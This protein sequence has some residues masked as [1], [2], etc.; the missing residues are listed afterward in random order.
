MLSKAAS[1]LLLLIHEMQRPGVEPPPGQTLRER[2]KA[3]LSQLETEAERNGVA[4]G[5]IDDAKYALVATIDETLAFSGWASKLGFDIHPLQ[6]E[7]FGDRNAGLRFYEKLAAVRQRSPEVLEV[8]HLCLALGFKG[9]YRVGGSEE[10]DHLMAEI[11]S[12]LG[13]DEEAQFA[14]ALSDKP[15]EPPPRSVPWIAIAGGALLLAIAVAVG[16]YFHL[17]SVRSDALAAMRVFG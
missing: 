2:I 16:L 15:P 11:A 12:E 3:K 9:R 17:D 5:D 14:R 1:D 8:Y 13:V 6:M 7:L 4:R 10:L